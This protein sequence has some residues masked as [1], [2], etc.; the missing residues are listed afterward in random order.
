MSGGYWNYTDRTLS[1]EIFS[2]YTDM[3]Y[4]LSGEK[5]DQEFKKAMKINP[6]NDPEISALI[7]DVFC[8]LHSYD[9]AVSGDSSMDAYHEDVAAFKER[10]F[11]KPRSEQIQETID[12][13]LD[14]L[15]EDLYQ[16]FLPSQ[17]VK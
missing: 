11:N 8:L 17:E 10:W 3:S 13:C 1:S 15:K 5:H 9:W 2:Y 4:G 12:T 6:L 7:Y 16:T 14:N